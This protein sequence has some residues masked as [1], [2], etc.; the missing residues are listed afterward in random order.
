M[1]ETIPTL[2]P[3]MKNPTAVL[4]GSFQAVKALIETIRKGGVPE[5]T[6]KMVHL[7]TSQINGRNLCVDYSLPDAGKTDVADE[8]L[9]AVA[10][11]QDAPCFTEAERAAL[12]LTEAVTRMSDQPDPVPDEIWDEATRHYDQMQLAA[13]TLSIATANLLNRINVT[14]RQPAG[15]WSQWSE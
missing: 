7:R 13:I 8:K 10:A 15:P 5:T 4:P 9:S 3:R 12:A 11:W 14:T 6:L 2:K 1:T